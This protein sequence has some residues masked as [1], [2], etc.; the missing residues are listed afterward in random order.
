MV[1]AVVVKLEAPLSGLAVCPHGPAEP[2]ERIE[3]ITACH[4]VP[5]EASVAAAGHLLALAEEAG[6][7]D[8]VLVLLSGGA[9]ALACLPGEG[10]ALAD[11]QALTSAL[12]HSGAPTAEITT[13]PR[14]LPPT[15]GGPPPP[16][17]HPPR[18][19]TPDRPRGGEKS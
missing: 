7:E 17:P 10:L 1:R 11:T 19:G 6:V 18:L 2:L 13:H 4:P 15:T 14:P 5:D 9:S 3:W 12:L 16:A 8:L